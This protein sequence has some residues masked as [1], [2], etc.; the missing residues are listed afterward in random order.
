MMLEEINTRAH[1]HGLFVMG[2][3]RGEEDP[4]TTVVLV[5]TSADFWRHFSQSKEYR[6]GN[7]DP[8][9]RWSKRIVPTLAPD[10]VCLFPSDGP[11]YAPFIAMATATG[12]FYQSPT[13]MLVHVTAGLMISMRGALVLPEVL[14]LPE[15]APNPCLACPDRPCIGGCPTDALSLQRPYDVPRCKAYLA[16]HAGEPCMSRG[17]LVRNKCPVSQ[18]FARDPA[19]SAFHMRAFLGE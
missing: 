15:P 10:A 1:P 13:G 7:P 18:R 6:D 4:N 12:Q 8:V 11:P 9:D 14:D 19:Q 5:G 17:C 3:C 16:T 2:A